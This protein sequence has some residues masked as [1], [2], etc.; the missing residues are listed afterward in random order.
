MKRMLAKLA[1]QCTVAL[2]GLVVSRA[3]LE[4]AHAIG[5]YP[6]NWLTSFLLSSPSLVVTSW[7]QWA[8]LLAGT[9]FLWFVIDYFVYR[10]E[11]EELF[12]TARAW[13]RK[14]P[15]VHGAAPGLRWTK[16]KHG[17]KADWYAHPDA[18]KH[19]WK[20][21]MLRLT[22]PTPL[23]KISPVQKAVLRERSHDLHK[24]MA[25]WIHS[26]PPETWNETLKQLDKLLNQPFR[27]RPRITL[28]DYLRQF[29][30]WRSPPT[31]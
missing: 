10:G 30:R 16:L 3:L 4:V 21:K 25:M 29:I 20:I 14:E 9:F 8:L 13:W 1:V 7:A 31:Y 26:R 11:L 28:W 2:V 24:E 6:E 5:W 23:E 12:Y 19:G 22:A 17:W 15:Y 18:V 27:P